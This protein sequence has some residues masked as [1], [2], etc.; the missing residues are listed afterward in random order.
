MRENRLNVVKIPL[1]I[2]AISSQNIILVSIHF[3]AKNISYNPFYNLQHLEDCRTCSSFQIEQMVS[4]LN[5]K[6]RASVL[7]F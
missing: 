7:I 5:M 1:L 3:Y 4:A 2:F 6:N